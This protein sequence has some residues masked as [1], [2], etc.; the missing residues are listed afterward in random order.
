MIKTQHLQFLDVRSYLSPN[1]SYD[2]FI[3]AYKC[4]IEKGFSPY[5][6]FDNY[7]KLSESKLPSHDLFCS[8]MKNKNI[9]DEKYNI[10]INAWEDN[11]MKI[12]KYFLEWYNNLDVLPFIEAVKKMKT[13]IK[14]RN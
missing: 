3:K 14:L 10:C 9:S 4:K 12:F 11:N 2:A 8:K 7:D 5:D 1:Y 6:Y 13:F